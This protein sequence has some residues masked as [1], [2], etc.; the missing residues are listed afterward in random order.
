MRFSDYF[1][2]NL[3]NVIKSALALLFILIIAS[4]AHAGTPI[5]DTQI[6]FPSSLYPG[7][8]AT[9]GVR[10][11]EVSGSDWAKDVTVTVQV[12]PASGVIVGSSSQSVSRIERKSSKTFYFPV[13][14]TDTATAGTRTMYVTVK[15]Y[16]MDLLNINT[17]GP[18]HLQDS[19]YFDVKNP[20]GKIV[21]STTPSN[22]EIYL[23]GKYMGTSP[24][25]IPNVV[26]GKHTVLLKKEGY[27][28]ISTSVAVTADS[29]SYLSKTLTQKTG[30]VR[31]STI[32]AGAQINIDGRYTGVSPMT[33]DSLSPGSHDI[34]LRMNDYRDVYDSFYITAGSATTYSKTMIKESGNIAVDSVPSGAGVYMG[35]IYR[36]TTPLR[37]DGLS[38]GTYTVTL[39]KEGYKDVQSTAIVKDAS[40]SSVSLSLERLSFTENVVSKVSGTPADTSTTG[41]YSQSSNNS[42]LPGSIFVVLAILIALGLMRKMVKKGTKNSTHI[43]NQTVVNNI[44]YG[45]KI[46]TNIRDS[47]VQRSN[48]GSGYFSCPHC[49]NAIIEGGHYCVECGNMVK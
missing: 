27:N 42:S 45:N 9:L 26:Q 3:Q 43:D 23:D 36:G 28:E 7:D 10:V 2:P 31:I 20:Y 41:S 47:V 34:S 30:S 12:S 6:E 11:S 24:M 4:P 29:E 39:S 32:P 22:T 21:V 40:T 8:S 48:F 37:I 33:V 25:T 35:S 17:L 44:H 46:Q 14:L 13:E 1:K 18:Y 16:E 19:Q 38:P 49:G 15:Y 5:I